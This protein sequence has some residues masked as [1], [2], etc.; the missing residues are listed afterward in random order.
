MKSEVPVRKNYFEYK[1]ID[2]VIAS[3]DHEDVCVMLNKTTA[4]LHKKGT[5]YD[6]KPSTRNKLYVAITRAHGNV[7][8]IYE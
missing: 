1:T 5:L 3:Y 2:I 8:L 7:Y 6:L 4:G